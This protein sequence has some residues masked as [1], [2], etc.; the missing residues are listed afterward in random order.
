MK[1]NLLKDNMLN[2]ETQAAATAGS[3][4]AIA[5]GAPPA[6]EPLAP[7]NAM[8]DP[9]P[10]NQDGA[11]DFQEWPEEWRD[12]AENVSEKFFA[13]VRSEEAYWDSLGVP[14]PRVVVAPDGS[15]R[16]LPRRFV[17]PR[18]QHAD[19]NMTT[20]YVTLTR[21]APASQPENPASPFLNR[22]RPGECQFSPTSLIGKGLFP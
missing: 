7:A 4:E 16:L 13:Y 3:S 8:A 2:D 5:S 22:R 9:A 21:E 11:F 10:A 20:E 17:N 14:W 6:P 19:I 12:S 18:E 15:D 1:A